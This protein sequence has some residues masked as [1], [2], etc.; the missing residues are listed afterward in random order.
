MLS[1]LSTEVI[2]LLRRIT[3][4]VSFTLVQSHTFLKRNSSKLCKAKFISF[5]NKKN[6]DVCGTISTWHSLAHWGNRQETYGVAAW[7]KVGDCST[8]TG[9]LSGSYIAFIWRFFW[10]RKI[11]LAAFK[12][13]LW[14]ML[15]QWDILLHNLTSIGFTNFI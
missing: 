13:Y 1:F 4:A 14:E 3:R 10:R 2:L 6:R 5:R 12:T 11:R 15:G 8:L 7:W 9:L